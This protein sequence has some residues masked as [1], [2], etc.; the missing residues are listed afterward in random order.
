MI[1]HTLISKTILGVASLLVFSGC[2]KYLDQAPDMR[3]ELNSPEKIGELLATAYPQANYITFTE[4]MSDNV[5]DKGSGAVDPDNSMPYFF[6]DNKNTDGDSPTNYWNAAYKAISAANH[7]LE[8]IDKQEGA[9]AYKP[10]KG[11][12]LVARAYAHFM[13]VTLFSKPY[14][15]QT[16]NTDP[17]IPYVTTTEKIVLGHYERK[18]VAYVYD[19][20]EKDL[21]EGMPLINDSKYKVPKYHF[22]RSAASAFAARFYL[23][24]K[25]YTN[26]VKYA[27]AVFSNASFSA[28]LRPV[29]STEYMSYQYNELQAQYTRAVNPANILLV[30]APTAWGRSYAT[31]RYGF[32]SD[33]MSKLTT[34]VNVTGGTW[35]YN[36][37][38]SENTINIPKFRE[39]F[40]RLTLNAESGIPYNMIP[41][42]SAEETLFNRAEANAMLGNFDAAIDDLNDYIASK[43]IVSPSLPFY[44]ESLQVSIDKLLEFYDSADR[45]QVLI[46]CILDFKRVN[47][48]FEGERWFDIIRHGLP[49][50]HKKSNGEIL[51]LGPKDPQRVFQLPEEVQSSGIELN[52]R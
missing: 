52:P 13:L 32:T 5:S 31:N 2:N 44:D 7:A 50:Q 41:I 11:E 14:S 25:D 6:K 8:I 34:S 16:S 19:M 51:T 20:I 21:K 37:Y 29:N 33:L 15:L 1:K 43:F 42:F 10:F 28:Y 36:I 26:S 23:Y 49:V 45:T 18:T 38:G 4:S 9:E 3:T 35:A 27:S 17:G 39:H 24:K 12:A 46:N 40:V 48:L 22:T 47:F 30:E